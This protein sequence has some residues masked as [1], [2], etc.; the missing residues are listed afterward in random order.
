MKF[1]HG[2][3]VLD[4]D[5]ISSYKVDN[6]YVLEYN[7][8][9]CFYDPELNIDWQIKNELIQLFAKDKMLP[10]LRKLNLLSKKR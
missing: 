8:G 2:F 5:L 3:I 4:K 1:A 10:F 9:I 7:G 6:V